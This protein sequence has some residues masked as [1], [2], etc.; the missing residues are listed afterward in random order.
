[1]KCSKGSQKR[2]RRK[3]CVFIIFA[4]FKNGGEWDFL[5]ECFGGKEQSF[6]SLSDRMSEQLVALCLK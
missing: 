1:M 2:V 3:G 4:V 5:A 6:E